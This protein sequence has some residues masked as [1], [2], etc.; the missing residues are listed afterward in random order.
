[1]I[2]EMKRTAEMASGRYVPGDCEQRES[3][4]T[5]RRADQDTMASPENDS[6]EAP[7]NKFTS[8]GDMVYLW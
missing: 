7:Q 4:M 8:F 1:M 5:R 2:K 6:Y 3:E